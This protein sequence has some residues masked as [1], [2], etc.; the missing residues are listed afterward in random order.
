MVRR[1]I[2]ELVDRVVLP[3]LVPRVEEPLAFETPAPLLRRVEEM[4][5]L[6]AALLLPR[7]EEAAALG[8]P[9]A[10]LPPRANASAA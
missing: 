10:L 7:V 5:A 3:D 1:T 4:L 8:I 6:E 9:A 2:R